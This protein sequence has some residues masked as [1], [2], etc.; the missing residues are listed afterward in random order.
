MA[1]PQYIKD[2]QNSYN[3]T[4]DI[5]QLKFPQGTKDRIKSI[6]GNASMADYCRQAVLSVL[7]NDEDGKLQD[8]PTTSHK[9]HTAQQA[10]T[11][12]YLYP[13]TASRPP[14]APYSP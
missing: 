14:K 1:L 5:I 3:A 12:A 13:P 6:I 2:A 11:A 9:P 10:P 8:I 4:K 7:K